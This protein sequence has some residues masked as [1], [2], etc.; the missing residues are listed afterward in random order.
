MKRLL[1]SLSLLKLQHGVALKEFRER[2]LVFALVCCQIS[3]PRIYELLLREPDFSSW[4][5][6]FVNKITGGPHE[7][8]L[9]IKSF[10]S[11]DASA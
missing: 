8:N 6:E 11:C 3:Y 5:P 2:Q 1:N 10:E 9:E 7:E 4:D